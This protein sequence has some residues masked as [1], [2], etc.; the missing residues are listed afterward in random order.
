LSKDLTPQHRKILNHLTRVGHI[1]AR[2]AII[3]YSIMSLSSRMCELEDRGYK[4][5]TEEMQHPVTHQRYV[6]Y[7]INKEGN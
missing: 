2:E 7:S 4:I 5:K 1:S 6:R 3:T